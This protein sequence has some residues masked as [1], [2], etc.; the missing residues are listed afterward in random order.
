[1][2]E[3]SATELSRNLS[4]VLDW[5][6]FKG[7]VIVILRNEHAVARLLPGLQKMTALEALVDL[8]QT[9]PED[10]GK[11]WLKDSRNLGKNS[12]RRSSLK[13]LVNPWDS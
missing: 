2:R 8:Y 6:E 1:M 13:N 11:S 12:K 5:V 7:E 4:R 10:A 9:L 3:M